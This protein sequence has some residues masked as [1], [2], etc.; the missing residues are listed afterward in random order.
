MA[1]HAEELLEDLRDVAAQVE[2]KPEGVRPFFFLS[3]LLSLSHSY[4][5][6]FPLSLFAPPSSVVVFLSFF[7]LVDFNDGVAPIYGTAFALPDQS[8]VGDL[9]SH[10][11]DL[12][13]KTKPIEAE[14][15][16]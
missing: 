2:A 1:Q 3:S 10:F 13:T 7:L 9:T 14:E 12:L 4:A 8:L 6:T 15:V 11:L 16:E 5:L